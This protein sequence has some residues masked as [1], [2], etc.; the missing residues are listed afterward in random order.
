MG[1]GVGAGLVFDA[2]ALIDIAD[3]NRALLTLIAR[4]IGPVIVPTPIVDEVST[5]SE[6]D[7]VS[8][9]LTVLE[10]SLE[11]L[12]EAALRRGRLSEED[13]LC[14]IVARDLGATC[15]TSDGALH[16][17]CVESGV[18]VWRGLKPL[19]TLVELGVL[20]AHAAIITVRTIRSTNA[21][22]TTAVVRAFIVEIRIARRR[23]TR[24][25]VEAGG[26]APEL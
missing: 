10:P 14:L 9:G 8:L 4:E 12:T 26:N 11:Q 18:P 22:I 25:S 3:A 13:H 17:A 6:A 7:C 24:W 15:V 23:A 16:G 2:S 1:Q 21:Y 5:L 19:I 20:E